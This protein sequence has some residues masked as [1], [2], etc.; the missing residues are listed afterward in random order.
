LPKPQRL[1]RTKAHAR[2]Y[3]EGLMRALLM[4][5]AA[6]AFV[7]TFSAPV[8]AADGAWAAVAQALGKPGTEMPGGVYRVA[9]PRTDLKETLDGVDLKPGFAFGGWVAFKMMGK[10]AMVMGDLVL[11]DTEVNPVMK[12]MEESGIEIT[13]LHNHLLRNQPFTMYMHVAGAGDPVKL[14]TALREAL[15]ESKT[16]FAAPATAGE[17]P[18][19][20]FDTA[21]VDRIM[22]YKGKN[23]GGIYG[24]T[25]PRAAPVTDGGM[26]V[27]PAMGSAT[28]INFQPTG[29][30]KAA[31]T[32]DFVLVGRE[33]N[34][35]LKA[36]GE[37]GI[38]VTALHSHMLDE[39]P[40][41]FFMHFWANDDAQKLA[42]GLKA[43][44]SKMSV[45]KS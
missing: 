1:D 17:P 44:L 30:G 31:I 38:E 10:Q 8:F 24:F 28:G 20:D 2:R 15:N 26:E 16:P 35:V 45:A 9:F 13:A 32:G 25:I 21:A 19:I 43:A 7:T 22:G 3:E 29:G 11:T 23:N 12:K 42:H 40:R 18:A 34:P 37:N 36:L 4:S 6:A 33:V 5:A 41:L 27:P 39:Q 14:A